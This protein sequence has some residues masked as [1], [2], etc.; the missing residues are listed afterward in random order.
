MSTTTDTP[1]G[2]WPVRV[3]PGLVI[4]A[5]VALMWVVPPRVAGRTMFHFMAWFAAPILG[6]VAAVGW[7]TF[8]ARVR[9]P[10]RW[11]V[12]AL[13]FV[14]AV[15]LALTLYKGDEM[16]VAIYGLMATL[17]VWI[18]WV[19][20]SVPV[21][22]EVRRTG[23]LVGIAGVW[24]L[25]AMLKLDG[26]DADMIPTFRW[27]WQQSEEERF[28]AEQQAAPTP[29]PAADAKAVEV[30]PG[31]WPEF[32]GPKRDGLATGVKLDPDWKAHPPEPVWKHRVGPGWG[33]FAV[34]GGKLFTQEQRDQDEAVVCYDAATGVEV[35]EY[36]SPGRF[37]ESIAGPGPRATPTIHGGKLYAQGATGKL[38]RLDAATGKQEWVADVVAAGGVLPQWGFAASPLV[39]DGVVIAYAGG[40]AG[41]GTVA[42]KADTGAV[43]WTAGT[44]K[45]GYS[46]AQLAAFGGVPQAL[47][48]SDFGLESF[49]PA[50]GAKLWEHAWTIPDVN[51]STQPTILSDTDVMIGTGVGND[52]GVRRLRV[53]K[54][55]DGWDVKP[56]WQARGVKPYFNDGVAVGGHFY[57]FDDDRFCCVDLESGRQLWKETGYGHGQVIGL[58][59]QGLLVV[60]GASGRVALVQADPVDLNELAKFPALAGKTWNH[61]VIAHGRLY[62][63]NGQEAACYRLPTR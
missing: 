26:L 52:Q 3:W 21:P 61:P 54:T 46:S 15:A 37:S 7:W 2:R 9:G 27:R 16:A 32:R 23:L 40:G 22:G 50:D 12:P 29:A 18:G 6:T 33:S 48:L 55:S 63:R 42:F 43:A 8:A 56:V 10:F 19:A 13:V 38:A 20:V 44:A 30:G 41:K 60:Q 36:K 5:V 14:P 25:G 4:L 35:W 17:V 31:D 24:V 1:D 49:R 28:L 11:L 58:P 59:D 53:T 34:A 62:V 57:G 45:H 39:T 47:V 51:R